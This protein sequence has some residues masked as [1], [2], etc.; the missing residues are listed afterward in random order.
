MEF[1]LFVVSKIYKGIKEQGRNRIIY[2]F[3]HFFKGPM[4]LDL[5]AG[6]LCPTEKEV[7]L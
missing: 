1:V 4:H 3:E 7:L 2:W 5:K 6:A